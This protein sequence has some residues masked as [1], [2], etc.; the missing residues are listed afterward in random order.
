ME[1]YW[2]SDGGGEGGIREEKV[3]PRK[4]VP[5]NAPRPMSSGTRTAELGEGFISK[6]V[7][8]ERGS[9]GEPTADKRLGPAAK[10]KL[11]SGE[12]GH[13]A[14]EQAQGEMQRSAHNHT[15]GEEREGK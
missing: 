4:E 15:G 12:V 3:I 6:G 14:E 5:T 2:V 1:A 11:A 10:A 8:N 13:V 7:A 9:R